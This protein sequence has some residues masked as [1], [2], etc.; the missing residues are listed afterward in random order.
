MEIHRETAAVAPSVTMGSNDDD[1]WQSILQKLSENR[2]KVLELRKDSIVGGRD[3]KGTDAGAIDQKKRAG[4][5]EDQF[6][7]RV[8]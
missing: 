5:S 8:P 4:A 7:E 2:V 6:N 1:E 3:D